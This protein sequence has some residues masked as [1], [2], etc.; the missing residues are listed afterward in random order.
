MPHL[1]CNGY[2]NPTD[3]PISPP[4]NNT[5]HPENPTPT[6]KPR[7]FDSTLQYPQGVSTGNRS[8]PSLPPSPSPAGLPIYSISVWRHVNWRDCPARAH[9]TR[10]TRHRNLPMP[11]DTCRAVCDIATTPWPP[12][13]WMRRLA[14]R[15]GKTRR[16]GD[17]RCR[18]RRC[19]VVLGLRG[20]RHR[21][22]RG[23]VAAHHSGHRCRLK[24]RGVACRELPLFAARVFFG[25]GCSEGR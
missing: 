2:W 21:R 8:T 17:S 22:G 12:V 6:D 10:R 16:G 1:T 3:I 18:V 11:R 25:R 15:L 7:P 4:R 9:R 23:V 13:N 19:I 20:V 14:W 5:P 24:C